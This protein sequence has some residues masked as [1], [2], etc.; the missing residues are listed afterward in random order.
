M[1]R[2]RSQIV[3]A[4]EELQE[5]QVVADPVEPEVVVEPE[6]T[7]AV[8]EVGEEVDGSAED[9][10]Q[11]EALG[12][13]AEGLD[14]LGDAVEA[15]VEPEEEGAPEGDGLSPEMAEVVEVAT[16]S[17]TRLMKKMGIKFKVAKP[18]SESFKNVRDRKQQTRL[19]VE[20][21]REAAAT[22][23]AAIVAFYNKCKTFIVGF[24]KSVFDGTAKL[25]GAAEKIAGAAATINGAAKSETIKA[26]GFAQKIQI[27]GKID[28]ATVEGGLNSLATFAEGLVADIGSFAA[29]AANYGEQ[30]ANFIEKPELLGEKDVKL[31]TL[32]NLKQVKS[33]DGSV[34]LSSDEFMGGRALTATIP[35]TWT[36]GAAIKLN[37]FSKSRIRFSTVEGSKGYEGETVATLSPADAAKVAKAVVSFT[38]TLDKNKAA[39]QGLSS[40][41]DKMVA[42]IK[43]ASSAGTEAQTAGIREVQAFMKTAGNVIA[44]LPTAVYGESLRAG[45]AALDYAA[46]SLS[47]YGGKPAATAA[48]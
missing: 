42:G 18:A 40:A 23:W 11:V 4:V 41:L 17:Y 31:N 19:A 21:L 34:V 33:A 12:E 2:Y 26:G 24:F 48:A 16:E 1:S 22:A 45:H 5:E 46:K 14:K 7:D 15:T 36:K 3:A 39:T 38:A 25:K 32:S 28:A 47:Q 8:A 10:E 37:V 20:G 44:Q 30:A 29:A 27:G 6:V 43:K 13:D 35:G 9:F